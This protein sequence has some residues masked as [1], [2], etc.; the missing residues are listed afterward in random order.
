MSD[1]EQ[2]TIGQIMEGSNVA[3]RI[4]HEF[5]VAV[6]NNWTIDTAIFIARKQKDGPTQRLD[7]SYFTQLAKV[8]EEILL[9]PACISSTLEE[10]A[11]WRG[12]PYLYPQV[13]MTATEVQKWLVKFE[14]QPSPA[15]FCRGFSEVISGMRIVCMIRDTGGS[16]TGFATYRQGSFHGYLEDTSKLDGGD[17][18]PVSNF[19][20]LMLIPVWVREWPKDND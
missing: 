2:Q 8:A 13:E 14:C 11:N 5:L 16:R 18:I 15:G 19:G 20:C 9:R 4:A 17:Y 6:E 1:S 10:N 7:G 12:T 3:T